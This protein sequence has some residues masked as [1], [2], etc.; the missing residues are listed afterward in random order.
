MKGVEKDME[1]ITVQ[2]ASLKWGIS[3]RQVQSLCCAGK[4]EGA[5]RF[6][7]SWAIPENA[8]KPADRRRRACG[9][10]CKE[11]LTSGKDRI[12]LEVFKQI[13]DRFPYSVNITAIDGTMIYG[14]EAFFTGVLSDARESALGSY[15]I[16]QEEMLEKWGLTEHIEKAFRGEQVVTLDLEFP[17]RSLI[18]TIYGKSYAFFSLYNDINSFPIFDE[19][20]RLLYVVSVFIP[21]RKYTASD[22]VA[23][24]KEYI[25]AH[26]A[27][28]FQTKLAAKA[29]SLSLSA[30]LQLFRKETGFTPHDYYMEIKMNHLKEKL[31]NTRIPISHAFNECGIDYNSYYTSLFKAHTGLTPGQFRKKGK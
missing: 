19:A 29:A 8:Q 1:Y 17:N 12:G 2:S 28:P 10:T 6:N 30:F 27:E 4:I 3:D 31:R 25:E 24:A 5:V 18:G 9:C 11:K 26:W 22:E 13:L 21:V 15:N 16:L 20:G 23:K 7:R 14:N